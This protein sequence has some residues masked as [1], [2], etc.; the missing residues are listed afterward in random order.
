MVKKLFSIITLL[1][2]SQSFADSPE[3]K[4]I[5]WKSIVKIEVIG[6]L[7]MARGSRRIATST[8][9]FISNDGKIMTARHG[10]DRYFKDKDSK[11]KITNYLGETAKNISL[12]NCSKETNRDICVIKASGFDL[13]P[14]LNIEQPMFVDES[15]KRVLDTKLYG[16]C[17][18]HEM[19]QKTSV[20]KVQKFKYI[21]NSKVKRKLASDFDG[22]SDS[23][24]VE[25]STEV[26]K[27]DSGGPLINK[28]GKVIGMV[29]SSAENR[30]WALSGRELLKFKEI[31]KKEKQIP[32]SRIAYEK[33]N[34]RDKRYKRFLTS[35]SLKQPEK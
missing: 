5:N 35:G 4:N 23:H 12:V 11:I 20:I 13:G 18:K 21:S 31:W 27:G 1:L 32:S 30:N 19:F 2:C 17:E 9:F 10:F 33:M 24:F 15:K 28:K 7:D 34:E 25:F 6:T 3:I 14:S 8:G 22:F 26:C 29:V 16:N